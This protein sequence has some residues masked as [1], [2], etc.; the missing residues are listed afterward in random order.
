MRTF[1][2]KV[3]SRRAEMLSRFPR[4]EVG[5]SPQLRKRINV[6]RCDRMKRMCGLGRHVGGMTYMVSYVMRNHRAFFHRDEVVRK[7]CRSV[8][9]MS[10]LTGWK[11]ATVL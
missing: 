4:G 8:A 6:Y 5:P 1:D 9:V 3:T 7:T 11:D 2:A 10:L